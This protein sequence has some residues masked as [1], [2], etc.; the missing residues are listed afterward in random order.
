MNG[1]RSAGRTLAL[2]AVLACAA[3]APAAAAGLE[4]VVQDDAVLLHRPAE[5]VQASMERLKALGVD[6]VRLTANWSTLTRET[7]SE[8][9]P[10]FDQTDPAAY[11]QGRWAGLDDAVVAARAAGLE[12]MVDLGFWGPHWA[13]SDP[14]G[15]RARTDV[16]PGAYA[17]FV[18]AALR[19]YS[20]SFVVPAEAGPAPA[21]SQDDTFLGGLFGPQAAP[22][23]APVA[24]AALPL[25]TQFTLWNE[26]NHPSLLLPQWSGKGKKARP[27]SPDLYRRMLQAATTAARAARPDAQLLVGN[28]SSAAGTPGSGAVPPLR[29][30]RELAC[31]DRNLAPLKTPQCADYTPIQGDGWA[32]H[33]YTRN[34][35]P[36]ERAP[37]TKPDDVG[38]ADLDKLAG[39]LDALVKKGRI[40][41]GLA[42]I[43]L[44]EFG[45]ETDVVAGRATLS[46]ATQA[47]WLTWAE[48][49][50]A[51]TPSVVTFAQFLLRD[52]PPAA[53]RVSDSAAR[54][55]G[56]YGTGLDKSDG[57]PKLAAATF[58]EGLF[59]GTAGPS[60][61]EL[62]VRL[63]L[64]PGTRTVQVQERRAG[65]WSVVATRPALGG[66]SVQRFAMD[67]HDAVLRSVRRHAG[68]RFRLVVDGGTPGLD[69]PVERPFVA[70]VPAKRIVAAKK[71]VPKA[72]K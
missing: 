47:R 69:V 6:R 20:G 38:I 67:G 40:A 42:K 1:I 44:T 62:F 46:Q 32:H 27:A 37:R 63:R 17:N 39:L 19:R 10:V 61:A 45:Y 55:F 54:A 58:T 57:T 3:A 23:A 59:A 34:H 14:A 52:Q 51:K 12:V 36:D 68:S 65:R 11:E 53:V 71:V 24:G 2:A 21:P 5:Q 41:P 26:P 25:V 18:V 28:T 70:P 64:A 29:F 31:V 8:T 7:D 13:T 30:I 16:D 15:P 33:P 48:R 72:T 35:R 22:A 9:V 50:V 66:P 43:H 56:Q 4:T 49:I 60:R